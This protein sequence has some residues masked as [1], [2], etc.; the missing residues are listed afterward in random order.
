MSQSEEPTF[1]RWWAFLWP[2]HRHELKK[3]IPMLL[4]FFL[5]SLNYNVLR[6]VKNTLV[7]TAKAS[8]AEVIPFIKV[9]VMLPMA[10]V[11][12]S[13]FTRLSNRFSRERVFYLIV[14]G[15]LVYFFVFISVMYPLRDVLHPHQFADTLQ[16]FLPVGC[17]GFVALIRYW[18]FNIFYVMSELWGAI[19][20]FLLFW[21]FVNEVTRFEEAKRFYGFFG[22]GAN[23][24][25]IAAGQVS[26]LLCYMGRWM[27]LP[28]GEDA[29][30][31]SLNLLIFLVIAAGLATM[32][33]FRWMHTN[34]LTDP[35]HYD[36]SQSV[37]PMTATKEKMSMR[38]NFRT[39]FKSKHLL[40]ITVIV[41]A[42]NVI[43]NLVEVVWQ[44]QL[45][46]LC[47]DPNDYS[48]YM[49]KVTTM[50]GLTAT[51]IALLGTGNLLR[52][53]GWTFT[54]LIA[55]VTLLITSILFFGCLFF[56][57]R[58]SISILLGVSPLALVVFWGALQN[59]I[60]R[61]VKY[62]VFDAT[63]ELAFVP[64]DS[65]VKLKGKTAIDGVCSRLG[66]S[67]G[68]VIHQG[69]LLMFSTVTACAPYIAIVLLIVIA[70]W[71]KATCTLGKCFNC[72]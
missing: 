33:I 2:I 13:I 41:V 65:E 35:Q 3:L 61:S 30:C 22:V 37:N 44:H 21:G 70:L 19:V 29:W 55:P 46:E 5:V 58:L 57:G 64:L 7:V 48:T 43:I 53:R 25:S 42:Y 12:T 54:A 62:T 4:M 38:Q 60:S 11:I 49:N 67:G 10:I 15:F 63:T 8:G 71:M 51:I 72:R 50:S 45:R 52:Y 1:N 9:W 69:L 36:P 47:P 18:T 31:Q 59:C 28:F 32:G 24:A 16:Q 34:V 14:G 66:K 39:I 6:T 26:I 27:I 68:A 40:N 17:N 20:L 56:K 23:V